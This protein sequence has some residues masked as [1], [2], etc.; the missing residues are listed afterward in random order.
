MPP[1]PFAFTPTYADYVTTTRAYLLRQPLLLLVVLIVGVVGA[2]PWVY[3]LSTGTMA[4]LIPIVLTPLI[5]VVLFLLLT[6][7]LI[8]TRA[9]RNPALF[10]SLTCEA[11]T[12]GIQVKG[13]TIDTTLDWRLFNRVIETQNYFLLVFHDSK[14]LFQMVPK[15]AFAGDVDVVRFGELVKRVIE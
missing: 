8:A 5:V 4:A 15:R 9:Q 10:E 13:R 2:V 14:K 6:P 12:V 7:M 1:I 11:I 3:V